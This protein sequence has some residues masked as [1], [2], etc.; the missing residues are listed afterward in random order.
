MVI[1]SIIGPLKAERKPWEM[2]F[3]GFLYTSIAIILS[4]WIFRESA[5]LVMVFLT[6][7]AA[8]PLMYKTLKFE[9]A[10]N[11]KKVSEIWLLKEHG[12][13]LSFFMT[14]FLGITL[15][16]TLWY[17]FLPAALSQS[18]FTT[19]AQTIVDIS[20]RVTGN[21][22]QFPIFSKIFLNNI[23][24]L[25]F[26][27]LFSFIYGAGAIFILTWNASVI[28]T[29][30]GNF[31]RSNLSSVA[32][33]AGLVK[34]A[35]YFHVFSLGL[36]RYSIHGIPEILA[37]FVGGLAGGIISVAIVKRQFNTKNFEKIVV[38]SADLLMIALVLLFVAALL[39]VFVT[40]ALF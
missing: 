2:V 32:Q 8:I 19:Q 15:A 10:K 40:P 18:L 7:F 36:L 31:I 37:Y 12:K 17:V 20:N 16:F 33:T 1:E 26:C 30:I 9:A 27:I 28:G 25:S 11:K 38:D 23:K 22:A 3:V 39:E 24:V 5:S 21:V 35:G 34:V 14:F 13:A 29:A 6:V 4:I